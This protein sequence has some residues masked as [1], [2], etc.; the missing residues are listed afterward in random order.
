M[1]Q[2]VF[3]VIFLS[4]SCCWCTTEGYCSEECMENAWGKYHWAECERA[5]LLQDRA[6]GPDSRTCLRILAQVSSGLFVTVNQ[7]DYTCN[8]L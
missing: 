6:L 5:Y 8:Y 4:N 3:C 7:D 1:N 2:Q